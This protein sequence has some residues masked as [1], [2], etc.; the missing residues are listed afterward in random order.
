MLQA[1][2]LY[3]L[4]KSSNICEKQ[5]WS[6]L[7]WF[8][9]F[10][11]LCQYFCSDLVNY[12]FPDQLGVFLIIWHLCYRIIFARFQKEKFPNGDPSSLMADTL[13]WWALCNINLDEGGNHP[14]FLKYIRCISLNFEINWLKCLTLYGDLLKQKIFRNRNEISKARGTGQGGDVVSW[15][16]V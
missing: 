12:I 13:S 10:D 5:D 11:R 8:V 16:N 2:D 9:S 14:S 7:W 15:G 3:S 1:Q 6:L 4:K